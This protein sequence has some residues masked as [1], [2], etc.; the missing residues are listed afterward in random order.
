MITEKI[1]PFLGLYNFFSGLTFGANYGSLKFVKNWFQDFENTDIVT[2]Y[3]SYNLRNIKSLKKTSVIKNIGFIGKYEYFSTKTEEFY[4]YRPLFLEFTGIALNLSYLFEITNFF[5][6][7]L[8]GGGGMA[9]MKFMIEPDYDD[10]GNLV[11]PGFSEKNTGRDIIS[12]WLML[13]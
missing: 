4:L 11:G 6:I 10:M 7:A 5:N 2:L 1:S 12:G 8:S 9:E 13:S 3:L